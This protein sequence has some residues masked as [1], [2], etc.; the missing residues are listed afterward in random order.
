MLGIEF[1]DSLNHAQWCLSLFILLVLWA[2]LLLPYPLTLLG[3]PFPLSL[4][5]STQIPALSISLVYF[6]PPSK[7]NRNILMWAF[8]PITLFIVC[9]LY[10][11]YYELFG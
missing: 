10:P 11:W 7:W 8:Q 1:L 3:C 2:S 9:G 4:P 6:H 5:P